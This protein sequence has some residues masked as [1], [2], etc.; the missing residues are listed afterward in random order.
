M[1]NKRIRQPALDLARLDLL[2][3]FRNF[4]KGFRR[5]QPDFACA[6]IRHTHQVQVDLDVARRH[7]AK[8]LAAE[9]NTF[10]RDPFGLR[11]IV[12]PPGERAIQHDLELGRHLL[13]FGLAARGAHLQILRGNAEVPGLRRLQETKHRAR[14]SRASQRIGGCIW[15][16]ACRCW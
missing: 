15:C 3:E 9:E 12:E 1:L 13:A 2:I 8:L 14:W 5:D 4:G 10:L 6:R 16:G 7:G 11:E